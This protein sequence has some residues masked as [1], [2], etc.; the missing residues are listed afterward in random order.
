MTNVPTRQN[1]ETERHEQAHQQVISVIKVASAG[2]AF[3]HSSGAVSSMMCIL[4]ME[5]RVRVEPLYGKL[6]A[7]TRVIAW[8]VSKY[9][10]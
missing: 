4:A 9:K 6:E 3:V 8:Q 5:P 2:L 1:A 10:K 7:S